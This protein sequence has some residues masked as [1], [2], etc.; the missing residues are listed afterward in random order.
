[1]SNDLPS[2]STEDKWISGHDTIFENGTIFAFSNNCFNSLLTSCTKE[3][4]TYSGRELL[5]MSMTCGEI[6]LKAESDR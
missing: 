3:Q 5:W 1:M 4:I 6:E 2:V